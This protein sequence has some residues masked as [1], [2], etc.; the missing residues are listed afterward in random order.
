MFAV[1]VVKRNEVKG[2]VKGESNNREYGRP[3]VV[4]TWEKK[5][6]GSDKVRI[7]VRNKK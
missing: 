2:I 3:E 5:A 1:S 7:K 4:G 6:R